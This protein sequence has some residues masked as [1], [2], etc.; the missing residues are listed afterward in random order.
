MAD[1]I[2]MMQ[3]LHENL[4]PYFPPGVQP[5]LAELITEMWSHSPVERYIR[6]SLS[7]SLRMM[8][9]KKADFF[10]LLFRPSFSE[11]LQRI[12]EDIDTLPS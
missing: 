9:L 4:R 12:T 11:I 10:R 1:T 6:F 5:A 8:R 7:L 3:V 2:F